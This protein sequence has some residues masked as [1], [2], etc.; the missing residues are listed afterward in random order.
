MSDQTIFRNA[1]PAR[2]FAQI[3]NSAIQDAG[4]SARAGWILML[5]LSLP[6]TWRVTTEWL[7]EKRR[8]NIETVKAAIRELEAAGYCKRRRCRNA[9]GT[10]GPYEFWFTDQRGEF[11]DDTPP[12]SE[13]PSMASPATVSPSMVKSVVSNT[14]RDKYT[15]TPRRAGAREV[16]VQEAEPVTCRDGVIELHG[17]ERSSYL[18]QF[19]GD[20]EALRLALDQA[21]AYIQPNGS[22][23]LI[24]QV[25][26]QLARQLTQRRDFRRREQAR[27][28]ATREPFETAA[29]RKQ[30]RARDFIGQLQR[31]EI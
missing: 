21:A 6:A 2:P 26:A 13:K 24:V 11:A 5:C 28:A 3:C 18:S 4:L 16:L 27:A 25:R 30:R 8:M 17:L 9:D 14:E 29:E 12:A 31:G 19:D 23:P 7:A 10:L 1:S 15:K 22:R 20:E